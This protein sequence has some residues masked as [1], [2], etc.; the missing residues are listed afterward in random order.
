MIALAAAK[1]MV[2]LLDD[3]ENSSSIPLYRANGIARVKTFATYLADR[4]KNTPNIIWILG[5]DFETWAINYPGGTTDSAQAATDNGLAQAMMAGI[6]A[7][8][9]NHLQTMELNFNIS[10]SQ[11]DPLLTPYV[12]LTAIYSYY[13]TYAETN[14]GYM[15]AKTTPVFFLEGY[16]EGTIY[17]NLTP[18]SLNDLG[19]RHQAY[20]VPFSGGL[21][22]YFTGTQYYDFHDG[23]QN[24]IRTSAATQMGYFGSFFKSIA[25]YKL[26]PDTNHTV[27]TAG[28][29]TFSGSS[30]G[31]G[32]GIGRID[33]NDYATAARADDGSLIV[34]YAPVSTVLTVDMSKMSGAV[35][36]RW[37]DPTNNTDQAVA[38]SP[39]LNV[40][41]HNFATPGKNF[42]GDPDW[43]LVLSLSGNPNASW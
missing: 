30:V 31:G 24:G 11:D 35:Y 8:D 13:P 42:A 14:V 21:A 16:Y 20:W 32:V 15:A 28:Y 25:W 17:W 12:S 41:T 1:D 22:G 40:G 4:Y 3:L 6:A 33:T 19:L 38:G 18:K 39:F 5:N 9:Q 29:G 10:Q 26:V 2:V 27:V 36:A 43:I 37:H 34:V 23:W 7:T